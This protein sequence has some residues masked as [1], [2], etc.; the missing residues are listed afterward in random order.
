MSKK[1]TLDE[2]N[3]EQMGRVEHPS[4][5]KQNKL[6]I[7]CIDIVREMP[8]NLGSVVKYVL[9]AGYKAEEGMT[10]LQKKLEDLK[11]A[12]FYL[13]DVITQTEKEVEKE[14]KSN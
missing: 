5:Y 8:F 1:Y 11:K 10:M 2:I 9:R 14:I 13:N 6:G 4:H 7:E 3:K 12:R